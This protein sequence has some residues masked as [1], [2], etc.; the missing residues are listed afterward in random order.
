VGGLDSPPIYG[1]FLKPASSFGS[2]KSFE[3]KGSKA[4]CGFEGWW[5]CLCWNVAEGG[6]N[7]I[8]FLRGEAALLIN[9]TRKARGVSIPAEAH[10][11]AHPTQPGYWFGIGDPASRKNQ[12]VRVTVA[13]MTEP[14]R[15]ASTTVVVP[16]ADELSRMLLSQVGR[17]G[18]SRLVPVICT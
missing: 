2:L 13:R 1:S 18:A 10:P 6:G 3:T 8:R 15:T 14:I 4:S 9:P 7:A 5:V 11:P 12:T 17:I 16:S